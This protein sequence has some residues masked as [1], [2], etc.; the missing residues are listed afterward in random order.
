ML[1][2]RLRSRFQRGA[3]PSSDGFRFVPILKPRLKPI[4]CARHSALRR[5]LLQRLAADRER[6]DH[7]RVEEAERHQAA[8]RRDHR[9][10]QRRLDRNLKKMPRNQL[11]QLLAHHPAA[12]FGP[13][14]MHDH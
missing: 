7:D 2:R 10:A 11:F 4:R 8:E 1:T 9:A 14:A 6:Q 13:A 5:R 3:S 12:L